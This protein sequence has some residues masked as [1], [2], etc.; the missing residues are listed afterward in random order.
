MTNNNRNSVT[1]A[2][3]RSL[4]VFWMVQG[5]EDSVSRVKWLG[6]EADHPTALRCVWKI[7]CVKL[8]LDLLVCLNG[9]VCN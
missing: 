2:V 7:D 3:S 1:H 9:T 8:Y 4:S 5:M 6:Y